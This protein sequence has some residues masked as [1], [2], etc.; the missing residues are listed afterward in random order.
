MAF[1]RLD[2]GL[3]GAAGVDEEGGTAVAVGQQVGVRHELGVGGGLDDH[4]S[5]ECSQVSTSRRRSR[6]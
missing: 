1:G 4:W 6:R 2:Q 3:D 5:A